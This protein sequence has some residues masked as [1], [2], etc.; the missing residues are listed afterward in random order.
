VYRYVRGKLATTARDTG[1][2]I[3]VHTRAA[4]VGGR[5]D[6]P[7]YRDASSCEVA[8]GNKDPMRKKNR[9]LGILLSGT[10]SSQR[11]STVKSAGNRRPYDE[12]I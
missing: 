5:I 7:A 10:F 8:L 3:Y 9:E 2:Y 11:I 4:R 12:Y 6:W 1:I